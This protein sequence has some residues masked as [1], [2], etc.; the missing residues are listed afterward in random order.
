MLEN[1]K[2]WTAQLMGGAN[3]AT[4]LVM[5]VV[6]YSDRLNPIDY[7]FLSTLGLAFPVFLVINC[8][9]LVFWA[10]FKLRGC[11]LPLVG[12]IVCY[13]PVRTYVPFNITKTAP[14]GAIKVMSY[15]VFLF[16]GGGVPDEERWKMLDYIKQQNA[17][18]LC[19]QEANL[20]GPFQKT[21]DSLFNSIYAYQDFRDKGI[22]G[23]RLAFYSKYPILGARKIEYPASDNFSMAYLLD[24]GSDT[25]IVINNHF[26][27]TGLTEEQRQNFKT[28]M[29]GEMQAG[30]VKNE[31]KKLVHKLSEYA[32]IRAPQVEAVAQFVREHRNRSVILCGDFNDSPISF[33][34]HRLAK[35]LTDCYVESGNGLGISYHCN[36]FYVRIDYIMCSPDWQP[37]GC[38]VDNRIKTSDHYPIFCWLK[39]L[40]K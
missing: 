9:F 22:T 14:E 13:A 32:Q 17:D 21:I 27:T 26:A 16:G 25:V 18:I 7:P 34:R 28:M 30:Q 5:L 39:K 40:R 1:M 38:Q 29:K 23:D 36:S 11:I 37:Y 33:A 20:G 6:G 8:A 2:K 3:V 4:I 10:F 15:N 19:L 31:S 35:E 24:L 12:F